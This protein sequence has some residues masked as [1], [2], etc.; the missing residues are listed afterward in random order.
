MLPRCSRL[1]IRPSTRPCLIIRSCFGEAVFETSMG[2]L[3]V[4]SFFDSKLD[5]PSTTGVRVGDKTLIYDL[6]KS[7][8]TIAEI[9]K[10][11]QKIRSLIVQA[12]ERGNII[13]ISD[14]K[15]HLRAF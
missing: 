3:Y 15:R 11:K 12:N 13:I 2:S 10:T 9:E 7:G 8:I 14:F 4:F 1:W 6:Y 5:L